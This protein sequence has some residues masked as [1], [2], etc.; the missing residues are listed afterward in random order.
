MFRIL[1]FLFLDWILDYISLNL[2][3]ILDCVSLHS[4]VCHVL[5]LALS[6]RRLLSLGCVLHLLKLWAQREPIYTTSNVNTYSK[7][8]NFDN[9]YEISNTKIPS[10]IEKWFN[11]VS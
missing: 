6:L 9:H 8:S 3:C 7:Y 5:L 1:N 11:A 2:I 10:A 4:C